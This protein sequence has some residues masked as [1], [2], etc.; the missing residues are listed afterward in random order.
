[1]SGYE[2]PLSLKNELNMKPYRKTIICILLLFFVVGSQI[3][4]AKPNV[5]GYKEGTVTF[6]IKSGTK[7][8]V[9]RKSKPKYTITIKSTYNEEQNGTFSYVLTSER[10]Q[11]I[12]KGSA[13]LHVG[14]NSTVTLPIELPVEE[15]GFYEFIAMIDI[16]YYS[17]TVRNVCGY[18]PEEYQTPLHKPDDFKAFWDKAKSDLAQIA[19]NYKVTRRE[20]K[21]DYAH[22]VYL[23]EMQSLD[24]VSI[25][26]WL[27]V[28]RLKRN[29]P[30]LIALP[31]YRVELKPQMP[32]EFALFAL[33][34]RGVGPSTGKIDP[35]NTEYNLW[36]IENK[37][38]YIYR[39]AYMDCVRAVDFIFAHAGLGLDLKRVAVGGGSQGAA[40][41][42]AVCGLDNRL[43]CCVAD[44][45]IYCD[46][47]STYDIDIKG[48]TTA[49]PFSRF[50]EYS[51]YKSGYD[52]YKLIKTLD[53]FDPQN[54]AGD[55]VCPVL[56][57]LGSLDR[58]ASPGTVYSIYNK[59][60]PSV[61][62]ESEIY[63][64]PDKAHE[65]NIHHG[66]FRNVWMLEK[67]VKPWEGGK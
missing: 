64:F 5:V 6:T 61:R 44:N 34:I 31:G 16:D 58:L 38:K 59:L 50:V 52:I 3:G 32:D 40:L 11:F 22:D 13:D 18:K 55:I 21:S 62:A 9:F 26:G 56:L 25:Y 45:P 42:L 19:P 35:K 29:Y 49:W 53:Y 7:D 60:S 46:I 33:N 51:R 63:V 14:K 48:K 27:T 20:D 10:H 41:A 8:A 2:N 67:F 30:V 65:I 57:G 36:G 28:P 24:T 37:N 4:F 23:V 15:P 39:G 43:S 66:R 47:H 1:M 17:D 54:F 12:A